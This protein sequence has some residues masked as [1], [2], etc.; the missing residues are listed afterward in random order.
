M[1]LEIQLRVLVVNFV[2]SNGSVVDQGTGDKSSLSDRKKLQTTGEQTYASNQNQYI[3]GAAW[4]LG[5]V[6]CAA[7]AL[8]I[9]WFARPGRLEL[10]FGLRLPGAHCP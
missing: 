7:K 2:I 10:P 1:R 4:S 5:S 9:K 3:Q 6:V 8:A